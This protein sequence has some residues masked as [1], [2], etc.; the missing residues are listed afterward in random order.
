MSMDV[1]EE[2]VVKYNELADIVG[3]FDS[4]QT[5]TFTEYNP[6]TNYTGYFTDDT[7]IGD[8][9]Y[10]GGVDYT[11][12]N[13]NNYRLNLMPEDVTSGTITVTDAQDTDKIEHYYLWTQELAGA[14]QYGP[15]L[16]SCTV[17]ELIQSQG[18][19][20]NKITLICP[21]PDYTALGSY[22]VVTFCSG[23]DVGAFQSGSVLQKEPGM[24]G[25]LK[26]VETK[27]GQPVVTAIYNAA[28]IMTP[29]LAISCDT[30]TYTVVLYADKEM[31]QPISQ[32]SPQ[33]TYLIWSGIYAQSADLQYSLS[34][35]PPAT[36]M[37]PSAGVVML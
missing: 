6:S 7:I 16:S 17:Q 2:K 25:D 9:R 31:T 15:A 8:T 18:W 30:T 32:A 5:P 19:T 3:E 14:R 33:D 29:V 11:A 22:G 12:S 26:F 36:Y 20:Q 1:V 24:T 23:K 35:I 10:F 21:D 4:Q 28:D 34:T 37:D 27:Q 13:P